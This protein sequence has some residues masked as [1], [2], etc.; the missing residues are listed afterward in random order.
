M[1]PAISVAETLLLELMEDMFDGASLNVPLHEMGS[2]GQH[3]RALG[4]DFEP[5]GLQAH[6]TGQ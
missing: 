1:Y 3:L 5:Q 4:F 6:H 2:R